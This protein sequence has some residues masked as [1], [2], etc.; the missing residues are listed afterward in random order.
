MTIRASAPG[1]IM[2]MGEHAVLAG[3]P[4]IVAAVNERVEVTLTRAPAGCVEIASAIGSFSDELG[5][6]KAEG[7]L[8]F[9]LAAIMALEPSDGLHLDIR[10]DINPTLGFGSSAAVTIAVLGAL[11]QDLGRNVDLHGTALAII[12]D[13]QGRGSGADLAASLHGGMVRYALG[14]E[15][16]A[17]TRPPPLALRHVG[18]KTPTGEVLAR[19]AETW[20][21]RDLDALYGRMGA[22]AAQAVADARAED[23]ESFAARMTLYQGLM[24]D[25]G[26]SDPAL[27]ALVREGA[28]SAMAA[29]ISG[30]GLGDCVLA[31]GAVPE[32]WMPVQIAG[33]GLIVDG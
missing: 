25:L 32:G 30:S 23:W 12:R 33:Q 2:V 8:R 13:L 9:V 5:A 27:E 10:S 29:K 19:V 7:P 6:L 24:E 21:G 15:P 3:H 4:A 26:V 22:V 17:L 20:A 1:S 11:A 31:L 28:R 14:Q 18:Y 16:E